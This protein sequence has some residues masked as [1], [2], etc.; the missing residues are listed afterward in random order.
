M[1]SKRQ[2]SSS[3]SSSAGGVEAHHSGS[4]A[5]SSRWEHTRAAPRCSGKPAWQDRAPGEPT[6]SSEPGQGDSR[7]TCQGGH[8]PTPGATAWAADVKW[9]ARDTEDPVVAATANQL[10]RPAGPARSVLSAAGPSGG[11]LRSES[12]GASQGC[13]ATTGKECPCYPPH[14]NL[15]CFRIFR[16]MMLENWVKTKL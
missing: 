11:W 5:A 13:V 15:L 2:T 3:F 8:H 1:F 16:S 9:P 12:D 7:A 6:G 14:Y 4:P 10:L